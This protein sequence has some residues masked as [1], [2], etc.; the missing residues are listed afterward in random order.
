[1]TET[2]EFSQL[3]ALV[4][5]AL[6]IEKVRV[7]SQVRQT[8]LSLNGRKDEE[9]D[10]LVDKL[11]ELEDYVDGRV[12]KLLIQHPAYDW[13]S[14]VK[15][16][17]R[18]NIGKV[19]APIHIEKAN[20]ISAL[21]KFAGYSVEEGVAARRVKGGGKLSYNSSLRTMC[22]R[23]GSSL[24]RAR[25]TFYQYYLQEKEKYSNRYKVVPAANLPTRD[26]KH[27]EPEGV[28]SEGHIH[29]MAL[30]KMIKLFLS[31]LWLTWREAEGLPITKPY[32]IDQLHH[33]SFVDPWSLVDKPA[34]SRRIKATQ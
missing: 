24:L 28:R 27:Y 26:G 16:I 31:C 4:D 9:T 30:R 32:A 29:N 7:R 12:A 2:K 21:W 1:M 20:T 8:H 18:E 15:G 17:G 11:V 10:A 33:D 14:R 23:L 19:L 5:A 34:K 22:W 25:G 6:A 13:F 3:S